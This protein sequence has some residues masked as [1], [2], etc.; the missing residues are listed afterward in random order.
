MKNLLLV[1]IFMS[2][3]FVSVLS[4]ARND[5]VKFS[6]EDAMNT[7]SA[8]SKLG[9][10]IKF[11][12]GTK[13]KFKIKTNFGNVMTNKKTNAFNKSDLKACQ[14]AF[15]SAMIALRNRAQNMGA[16]AVI[17]IQSFYRQKELNSTEMFE[18]GAGNVIAGVALKADIVKLK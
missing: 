8:K 11:S 18:C 10:N 3:T 14:W 2:F 12:F 17:N 6:I 1:S 4:E 5:R 16:D 15:L 9:T 7:A 13:K